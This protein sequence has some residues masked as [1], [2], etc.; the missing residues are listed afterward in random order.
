M[1]AADRIE[2]ILVSDSKPGHNRLAADITA[3]TAADAAALLRGL[4]GANANSIGA[5]SG[6]AQ[7]RGLSGE[8]IAVQL[9]GSLVF[10]GGPNAMYEL[11]A[12]LLG[13]LTTLSPSTL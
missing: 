6:I 1:A 4:P 13:Q 11:Y 5:L 12:L 7:Y 8:R 10:S 9:D 2:E 3:T